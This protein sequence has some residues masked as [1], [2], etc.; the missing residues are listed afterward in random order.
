MMTFQFDQCLNDK[1]L[2]RDCTAQG[3]A[4]A[5]CFPRRLMN[6]E[7]PVVLSDL[8]AKPNPLVTL[9]LRMARDHSASIP[10]ANP[11]M[12]VIGNGRENPR[13]MTS[14]A[15][16]KI[17]ARFKNQFP[18]WH[19]TT[20]NNSIVEISPAGVEIWH[21]DKGQLVHDGYISVDDSDWI[22]RF[23]QLIQLN[24]ERMFSLPEPEG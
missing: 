5:W 20:F 6:E 11:G 4:T 10:E 23:K 24:A 19:R 16:R 21:V 9:D 13:T 7:D 2:A 12:V 14:S 8:L 1:K 18:D 3:L 22:T 15:A 17:L